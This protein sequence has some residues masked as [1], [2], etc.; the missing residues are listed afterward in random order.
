MAMGL[1]T[2]APIVLV[3]KDTLPQLS[4]ALTSH[5]NQDIA[6]QQSYHNS[7]NHVNQDYLTR[8]RDEVPNFCFSYPRVPWETSVV[9]G[10]DIIGRDKV[11][12]LS[13]LWRY[14]CESECSLIF[15]TTGS[16]TGST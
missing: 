14:P 7:T 10:S 16:T 3:S 4:D 11:S 9:E 15:V 2:V 6:P 5:T 13:S 12:N 1:A 8:V